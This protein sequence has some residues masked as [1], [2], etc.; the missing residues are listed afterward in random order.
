MALSAV[1]LAETIAG[2]Q[3]DGVTIL[4]L[5]EIPQAIDARKCP[6]VYPAPEKF[7]IL[8]DANQITLGPNALWQYTYLVTYRYVQAPVGMERG[9]SKIIPGLVDGYTRF[10]RAIARNAQL[11]GA[12]HV[13]PVNTPEW[14]VL[15]DPS[16]QQF[17]AADLALRV[18]E[19]SHD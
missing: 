19:F 16:K 8:E 4:D 9:V 5:D 2:L 15:E 7:M 12:A 18:V 6:Q 1:T 10:I 17:Q 14:G 3:V 11:L 13:K